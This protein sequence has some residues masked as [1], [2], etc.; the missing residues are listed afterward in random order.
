MG[1][2]HVHLTVKDFINKHSHVPSGP[3]GGATGSEIPRDVGAIR[4]SGF[5]WQIT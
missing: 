3:L 1:H 4:N 5:F 2:T